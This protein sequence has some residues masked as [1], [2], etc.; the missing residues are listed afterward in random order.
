MNKN[1]ILSFIIILGISITANAQNWIPIN[2]EASPYTRWWWLGSAVDKKNLLYNLSEYKKAG[3]GGVEITPIY[4]VKGNDKNEIP[5]L[6][7]KW[8]DMLSFTESINDSLG[9]ETNMA[10]GT[11]WPF[12]GPTVS[13]T[14]SAAKA[15]FQEYVV[16]GGK[17]QT[18][19]LSCSDPKQKDFAT[20]QRVMAYKLKTL[21]HGGFKYSEVVDM[22]SKVSKENNGE[23]GE[24]IKLNLKNLKKGDWHIVA[25]YCGRTLQKVKRAAPG[26]EGLVV[27]HF[28][29]NAIS[30]YFER[31]DTAFANQGVKTPQTFFNDSYEVYG[32]DW[33]PLL[34]DEFYKRRGY[35]LENYFPD[36]LLADSMKSDRSR[37]IM[38]DYRMTM[39]ELL[40][41]NF[42]TQW[43]E[44][45]HKHNA[46]TRNQAHGSPANLIDI[47]AAVD[48]PEC[49]GFGL[50]DFGIKGLRNDKSHTRKN[51]SDI[52]MLKYASSAA[53]ISGKKY[54]SSETFTWLTEHFRT[55]L[56]QCKPDLDLFFISG[57]NH[58]FFHGTCYSPKEVIWPG[59]RF[60]ASVDISPTN[61]IWRDMP[62]F[63]DYI[64]RCQSFLQWG[65]PDNDVLVYL[66]YYDM[67]YEQP[68]RIALFDI[69]SMDKRAPK[70]IETVQAIIGK[71]YDVDY[72]SDKYI[73]ETSVIK[74]NNDTYSNSYENKLTTT[75]KNEYAA[76]IIPD[77]KFMPYMTFKKILDLAYNGASVIFV[78][79][80][81]ESAPGYNNDTEQ[82]EFK[83]LLNKLKKSIN[84]DFNNNV[85]NF[86]GKGQIICSKDYANGLTHCS[87]KKELMRI[88][89]GL[90]CIRRTNPNGYHYFISN[91]QDKDIEGWI[92]LGV[93]ANDIA[94]Y[95]PMNGDITQAEIDNKEDYTSTH[96]ELKSG[97]SCILRTFTSSNA[98]E[99]IMRES[100]KEGELP[101]HKYLASKEKRCIELDKGWKLHFIESAPTQITDTFNIEK[102]L[103]WTEL[104]D[105]VCNETMATGLYS[106]HFE[107]DSASIS[108]YDTFILNL[109]DVRES[110]KIR[111]NEENLGTLFAVPFII[112]ISKA[113]KAGD[114]LL[115][116]EVTNLPANRIAALDREGYEWRKFKEI[117]VVDLNYK[118]TTYTDWESVPSGLNSKVSIDMINTK[119]KH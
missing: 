53:H 97:E 46:M 6:S 14:E 49:E 106:V 60:Y 68:D 20:L 63:S 70:F 94:I 67:I 62:A 1:G 27:D 78:K 36:F 65:E 47:Y 77:V 18:I 15:I 84:L 12:G 31:F 50:S 17:E 102:P 9:I 54:T 37:R 7:P 119:K 22:T 64:K 43:T 3:I 55:S 56:S 100:R 2:P 66:P 4:G 39:G 16:V 59:W 92:R 93:K 61:S 75:G 69:H 29:R 26:G 110:A 11:G 42:T 95:N 89:E 74:A 85:T 98:S 83:A 5:Y 101:K 81:P 23:K 40:H 48:I 21:S 96:I 88:T 107:I 32:A 114:N 38:S 25:L 8:M 87:A 24:T 73:E 13:I 91:L 19:D 80:L 52:S 58:V 45:A 35:K 103:A 86:Y 34:L 82:E 116:V 30:H 109:G 44:W 105:S 10:T 51:F 111:L 79:E 99:I 115:E 72:I 71:G 76:I 118:K 112:D 113:V 90:S 57:I 104:N 108:K 41:D 117:N 28:D 33:T